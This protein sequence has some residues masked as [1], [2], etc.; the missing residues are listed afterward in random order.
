M[1]RNARLTHWISAHHELS[2]DGDQSE[3]MIV[4]TTWDGTRA[5]QNQLLPDLRGNVLQLQLWK[6]FGYGKHLLG[7]FHFSIFQFTTYTE[8]H[9]S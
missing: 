3:Q 6:L 5:M 9:G 8:S 2:D 1:P 7:P 4:T